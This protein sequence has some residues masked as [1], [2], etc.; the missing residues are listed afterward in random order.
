MKALH[1]V[2]SNGPVLR[3][4]A[5]RL[6]PG[7]APV[8]ASVGVGGTVSVG[9][10]ES[11]AISVDVQ[12]PEWMSFDALDLLTHAPGREATD[13]VANETWPASRILLTQALPLPLPLEGVPGPNMPDGQPFR[14][15]HVTHRFTVT[16]AQDT[17]YVVL[18]RSST[19]AATLF[20]MVYS[21]TSCDPG[22]TCA[23]IT[24]RPSAFSNPIFVDADGTGAYDNFPLKVAQ[25]L[26]APTPP[27]PPTPRRVPTVAELDAMISQLLA[28]P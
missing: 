13:G 17:W 11:L 28:E 2:G 20:P 27:A 23:P 24:A 4:S 10:G 9:T 19:A 15:V 5:Q 25:G 14:R 22:G 21:G 7:G 8:G 3:V 16:P 6:D 26:S 18:L 12:A 1:A